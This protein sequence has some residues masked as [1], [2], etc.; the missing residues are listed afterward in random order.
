MGNKAGTMR[1]RVIRTTHIIRVLCGEV[2]YR[3]DGPLGNKL[4]IGRGCLLLHNLSLHPG[5]GGKDARR[6]EGLGLKPLPGRAMCLGR[7][8]LFLPF[9]GQ[10]CPKSCPFLT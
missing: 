1:S 5:E 8:G 9:P 2:F 3:W 6:K 7:E 4:S 10:V